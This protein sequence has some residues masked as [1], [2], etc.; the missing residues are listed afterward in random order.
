MKYMYN[1]GPGHS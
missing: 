1:K